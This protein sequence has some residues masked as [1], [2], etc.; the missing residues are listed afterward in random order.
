[1]GLNTFYRCTDTFGLA[2]PSQLGQ[3]DAFFVS[4]G[5]TGAG[6]TYICNTPGTITFGSTN[7]TFAEISSSQIYAAGTGL[8]PC[9]PDV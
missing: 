6:Q 8:K 9:Q 1:V 4:S 3:G 2:S 7:I 5:N